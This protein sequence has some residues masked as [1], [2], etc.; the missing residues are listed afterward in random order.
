MKA[1]QRELYVFTKD[2]FADDLKRISPECVSPII[3]TRQVVK[4]SIDKYVAY[5][6]TNNE[7]PFSKED[8]QAVSNQ[9]RDEIMND[10]L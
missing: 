6:C 2:H 9:I 10:T 7:S 4:R 3:A 1:E 5:Y 8:F